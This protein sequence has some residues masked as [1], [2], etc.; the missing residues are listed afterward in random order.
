MQGDIL[1]SLLCRAQTVKPY[2]TM[3][4]KQ[5]IQ[6][7]LMWDS[8]RHALWLLHLEGKFWLSIPQGLGQIELAAKQLQ[9]C[10]LPPPG[11]SCAPGPGCWA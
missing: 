1:T 9:L 3:L 11:E 8:L 7:A 5:G 4:P 6:D 2:M 10:E